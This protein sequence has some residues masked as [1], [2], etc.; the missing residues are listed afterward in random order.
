MV[1]DVLSILTDVYPIVAKESSVANL[2]GLEKLMKKSEK[3]NKND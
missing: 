3:W 2:K 1:T